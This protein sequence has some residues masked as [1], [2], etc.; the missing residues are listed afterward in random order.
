MTETSSSQGNWRTEDGTSHFCYLEG[1]QAASIR[2]ASALY[3]HQPSIGMR[4][5][6]ADAIASKE[7][8]DGGSIGKSEVAAE[9]LTC[10]LS[11]S[12]VF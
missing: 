10:D 6:S 9:A 7:V 3:Q 5:S 12:P 1:V 2:D 4:G 8:V 11:Q